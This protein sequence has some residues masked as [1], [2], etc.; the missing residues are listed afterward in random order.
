MSRIDEIH[1]TS[2]DVLYAFD[3]KTRKRPAFID[4][5]NK[6]VH[7]DLSG[8]DFDPLMC[9]PFY[10]NLS[11]PDR[12]V[13]DL[14]LDC[15]WT[16]PDK[17]TM[18]ILPGL[19][20]AM[21]KVDPETIT[22]FVK[23]K[24]KK[25]GEPIYWPEIGFIMVYASLQE[26]F[27]TVIKDDKLYIRE[28]PGQDQKAIPD[29]YNPNG[30]KR[31][32]GLKPTDPGYLTDW[33]KYGPSGPDEKEIQYPENKDK[34]KAD[35]ATAPKKRAKV[36]RLNVTPHDVVKYGKT[37]DLW[38][39]WLLIYRQMYMR[40][41]FGQLH[42]MPHYPRKSARTGRYY[43]CGNAYLARLCGVDERTIRLVLKQLEVENLIYTR[44][45]GHKGRGCSIIEVPVNKRHVWK[46]CRQPGRQKPST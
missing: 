26:N 29:G 2:Q 3:F 44:Y 39:C 27:T 37:L 41:R 31:K 40:S 8:K 45:H 14:M 38:A 6:L 1:G 10:E 17:I 11:D 5:N 7:A 34:E 15:L 28:R 23:G 46:W 13:E 19:L 24:E 20:E 18:E 22:F 42:D 21:P 16:G 12:K 9:F 32:K 30:S 35:V 43:F 36:R 25:Q 33:T 4:C